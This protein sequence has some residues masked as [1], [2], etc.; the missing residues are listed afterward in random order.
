MTN[1]LED[2]KKQFSE[3]VE[4]FKKFGLYEVKTEKELAEKLEYMYNHCNC[5]SDYRISEF[6]NS[7]ADIQ[8]GSIEV[9]VGVTESNEFLIYNYVNYWGED[10]ES[11]PIEFSLGELGYE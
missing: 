11:E 1:E 4:D 5:F 8:Y 6:D 10:D 2:A 3:L 9:T 7:F